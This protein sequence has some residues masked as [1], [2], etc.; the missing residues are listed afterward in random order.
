MQG[1]ISSKNE[2]EMDG[3]F[4]LDPDY[5]FETIWVSVW[6]DS[7]IVNIA[8]TREEIIEKSVQQLKLDY[9]LDTNV[10]PKYRMKAHVSYILK[11]LR[12]KNYVSLKYHPEKPKNLPAPTLVIKELNIM[13]AVETGKITV[14]H[15]KR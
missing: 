1:F 12:S 4:D 5:P 2:S 8:S 11:K 9:P 15:Y 7:E 10:K 13:D 14:E 6:S 3:H